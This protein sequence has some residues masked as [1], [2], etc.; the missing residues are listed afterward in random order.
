MSKYSLISR[1]SEQKLVDLF[2]NS[3]EF[4]D[5]ILVEGA[6]QVG[7]TTLLKNTL[8]N[9]QHLW[10][11]L[12]QDRSLVREID[13]TQS[14]QEFTDL[15]ALRF[16]F[17]PSQ[18]SLLVIDEAQD[19]S[20]LG[21]YVRYF[22]EKW[23]RQTVVLL[24]SLMHRLFRGDVCF[25]V[26][27]VTR[28]NVYPFNF[29][30]FLT[31]LEK[32]Y[33]LEKLDQWSPDHYFHS[34]L[35]QEFLNLWEEYVRVG[36]LPAVVLAYKNKQDW[37]DRLVELSF[38]YVEDFKRIHGEDKSGLFE[39]CLKRVAAT[40]GSP[41]K[42]SSFV[43]SH[44]LAYRHIPDILSLL[45]NWKL[46]HKISVTTPQATNQNKIPPKRYLF[47]HGIRQRFQPLLQKQFGEDRD[48]TVR[49][50]NWFGGV[51]ENF[52]LNELLSF[53]I[54]D[55]SCWREKT[56]GSEIDFVFTL[57]SEKIPLEVKS[58]PKANLHFFSPINRFVQLHGGEKGVLV[59]A[60]AGFSVLKNK[61]TNYQVPFYAFNTFLKQMNSL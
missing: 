27:R 28:F 19:S 26:G 30:E 42:L 25:P 58:S 7:K 2:N 50:E 61:S 16:N 6:R 13:G 4:Q 35:H 3:D 60:G 37:Q 38:D 29:R 18:G 20:Q 44:Q 34:T 52:V 39:L 54:K 31:T 45:E 47:D 24:G 46:V 10:I 51:C 48:N 17:R 33:L 56:N 36:G 15:L 23:P 11:D 22:K 1:E 32:D 8:K 41:S 9:R 12:Q 14:F 21:S 55:V 57:G 49:P 43:S 59:S 53:G 40:L 5:V